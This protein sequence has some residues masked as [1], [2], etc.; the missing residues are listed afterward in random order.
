VPVSVPLALS[1]RVPALTLTVPVLLKVPIQ[2]P[3]TRPSVCTPGA[4]L[5]SV[6]AFVNTGMTPPSIHTGWAS[7]LVRLN[8]PPSSLTKVGAWPE[9]PVVLK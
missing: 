2:T 3:L 1:A 4:F 9:G 6:P 8:T 7:V 5:F